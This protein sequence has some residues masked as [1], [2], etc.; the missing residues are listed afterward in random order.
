METAC[1]FLFFFQP[2]R[3]WSADCVS[4]RGVRGYETSEKNNNKQAHICISRLNMNM[5]M[6][7]CS[8]VQTGLYAVM[9]LSRITIIS[10]VQSQHR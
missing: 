8:R 6:S 1:F 9:M 2:D 10:T 4:V 5:S 3:G 7:I